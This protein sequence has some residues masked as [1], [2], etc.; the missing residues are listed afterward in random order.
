MRMN[1]Q[2]DEHQVLVVVERIRRE[3]RTCQ[4][5]IILQLTR[6]FNAQELARVERAIH[7]GLNDIKN[8][9]PRTINYLTRP[10]I[11]DI[12]I[13]EECHAT[14]LTNRRR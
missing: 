3:K 9:A 7:V 11:N 4:Q 12:D 8:V 1:Y 5:T 13:L 6:A 2:L 14:H 10:A